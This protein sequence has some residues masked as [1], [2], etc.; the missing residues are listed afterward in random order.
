MSSIYNAIKLLREL[1]EFIN[2]NHSRR[3]E[4]IGERFRSKYQT[5]GFVRLGRIVIRTIMVLEILHK[6]A[7]KE[8]C[9]ILLLHKISFN[10]RVLSYD[11]TGA[12]NYRAEQFTARFLRSRFVARVCLM[13]E[14]QL[15][16]FVRFYCLIVYPWKINPMANN[17]ALRSDKLLKL[18]FYNFVSSNDNQTNN[19]CFRHLFSD[20]TTRFLKDLVIL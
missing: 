9:I 17:Q 1:G 15:Q 13:F 20:R 7:L 18:I 3:P 16:D 19:C 14:G 12:C 4:V 10:L 6:V 8:S 2:E 11:T 5:V